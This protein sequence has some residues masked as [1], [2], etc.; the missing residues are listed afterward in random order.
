MSPLVLDPNK[1]T[2]ESYLPNCA[3][4]LLQIRDIRVQKMQRT[5]GGR[6][7][8]NKTNPSE[9]NARQEIAGIYSSGRRN[10]NPNS[11]ISPADS[12]RKTLATI[13]GVSL[14]TRLEAG[15]GAGIVKWTV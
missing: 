11:L 15:A 9:E 13:G 12:C 8:G 6:V 7:L 10:S 14:G 1:S 4:I 3:R 5:G 2:W